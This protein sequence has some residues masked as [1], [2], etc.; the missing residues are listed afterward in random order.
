MPEKQIFKGNPSFLVQRNKKGTAYDW[1]T[2]PEI[3]DSSTI[4]GKHSRP[5]L[6]NVI[7]GLL[8]LGFSFDRFRFFID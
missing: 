3:S 5:S 4:L 1:L 8:T 6:S 7:D 2:S